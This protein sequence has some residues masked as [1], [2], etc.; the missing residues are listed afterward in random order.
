MAAY[1]RVYDLRHLQA[2]CLEPGSAPEP[3]AGKRVWATFF[4][5]ERV[6]L[7]LFPDTSFRIRIAKHASV[8]V[9]AYLHRR[10]NGPVCTC[11]VHCRESV[12]QDNSSPRLVALD[13]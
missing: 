3:Y 9:S 1:R 4:I 12:L 8:H 7:Q 5:A 2:D 10:R 11:H 6:I 13:C